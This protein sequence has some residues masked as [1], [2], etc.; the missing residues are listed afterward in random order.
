MKVIWKNQEIYNIEKLTALSKY[1]HL[2][3]KSKT[4]DD[5]GERRK[6]DLSNIQYVEKMLGKISGKNKDISYKYS[7]QH[8]FGR[9]YSKFGLQGLSSQ[10]RNYICHENC[11]DI[12]IVNCHPVLLEQVFHKNGLTCP[13]LTEYVKDRSSILKKYNV[14][15]QHMMYVMFNSNYFSSNDF[16]IDI[17]NDIFNKLIPILI[18][19]NKQMYE[20]SKEFKSDNPY[21]SFIS[22]YLQ[23]IE[24]NILFKLKSLFESNG[25]TINALIFDGFLVLNNKELPDATLEYFSKQITDW[26]IQLVKKPMLFDDLQK[27]LNENDPKQKVMDD[28]ECIDTLDFVEKVVNDKINFIKHTSN[29]IY[30]KDKYHLW[31]K[32]SDKIKSIIQGWLLTSEYFVIGIAEKK[33]FFKDLSLTKWN[34]IRNLIITYIQQNIKPDDSFIDKLDDYKDYIPFLD[35]KYNLITK[36]FEEYD[37]NVELYLTKKLTYDA[38]ERPDQKYTDDLLEKIILPIFDDNL[39]MAKEFFQY[40]AIY[41][42]GLYSSKL[43]L[44]ASGER[45]SGKSLLIDMLKTSFPGFVGDFNARSFFKKNPNSFEASDRQESFKI[46]FTK[47]RLCCCSEIPDGY[48][49]NEAIKSVF[50]GG[51]YLVARE[52]HERTT[53]GKMK[54]GGIFF[55]NRDLE[56]TNSDC[57]KNMLN[58][59][60]PCVFINKETD[61]DKY[62]SKIRTADPNI[63]DWIRNCDENRNAFLFFIFD[64]FNKNPEFPILKKQK[65][66]YVQDLELKD[67][68]Q[69][70][71]D[72]FE[73][74]DDNDILSL[75]TLR[76][77]AKD[78]GINKVD[79][80][81]KL[82]TSDGY[83]E[84][85]N[86]KSRFFKNI[87]I[88]NDND[89]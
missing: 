15:K 78:L 18:K 84:S 63:K 4:D 68:N 14:D 11:Y 28:N 27:F 51:D 37:D 65:D 56:A 75:N 54:A 22:M 48:V 88:K 81:K 83:I 49:D 85:R 13:N 43:W 1:E 3:F 7:N 67:I 50:S 79:I 46:P 71:L 77:I 5:N 30:L 52:A 57:Y 32:D 38:P 64:C 70:F 61:N 41:L 33:E 19:D 24:N 8:N 16:F 44:Y 55:G 47:Y 29:H 42:G 20:H 87:K 69:Q 12:D 60:F 17:N 6:N 82:L 76:E 39:D 59:S 80:W 21:G 35:K 86:S 62:G 45:N 53:T 40:I 26:N 2:E 74:G 89:D 34:E 58:F 66:N 10:I 23:T 25:Y 72:R 36:E 31:S 9:V 73:H